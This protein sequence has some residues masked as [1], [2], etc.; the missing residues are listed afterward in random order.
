[1]SY[2][3]RLDARGPKRLLALD[4]G[5]IRGAITLKVLERLESQLRE[6]RGD[7]DLVLADVFDYIG[8][9]STGA[10]T[11]A[12]LA[13][14]LPVARILQL[15]DDA[16]AEMFTRA[17]LID[18]A[19]HLY[20]ADPLA[21]MLREVLGADTTLGSDRLRTL[22]LVVLANATTDSPWPMSNNPRARFN[23]GPPGGSNLDL[24]L[25]QLVRASTAAPTF[26]PPERIR[27]GPGPDAH[28]FVFVDGSITPYNDPAFQ[29]FLMATLDE[30]R[31][32]WPVGEEQLLLVSIGTGA[33]PFARPGLDPRS[34]HL[35]HHAAAVPQ[36]LILASDV[37][38]DLLCRIF[39]RCRIGPP[40]DAELGDLIG[41]AGVGPVERHFTYVRYDTWLDRPSLA[42]LGLGDL[43]PRDV[44]A[45]DA[46]DAL[47]AL[48]R[49][50]E[51]VADRDIDLAHLD[52]FV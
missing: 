30:Y 33:T 36:A 9:T 27:L 18:R 8:G 26:F 34:M 28:E 50:G 23:E 32:R 45:I 17:R 7:P 44:L 24:P 38:Q 48:L 40:I 52:G 41:T 4:G 31:L 39:G 29:L 15:Y 19:R 35:L 5:G 3:E 25:W 51:A 21:D 2:R 49:I 37:Q 11:A 46:V 6:A 12:G 14:G 10:I 42:A 20:T 1:M 16:A 13:V 43:E 22:L 47:P